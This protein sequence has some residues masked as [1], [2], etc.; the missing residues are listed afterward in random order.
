MRHSTLVASTVASSLLTEQSCRLRSGS[1]TTH[2]STG[3][4]LF[5]PNVPLLR[6]EHGLKAVITDLNAWLCSP[7][8]GDAPLELLLQAGGPYLILARCDF[9]LITL[10]S[11][12]PAEIIHVHSS[13]EPSIHRVGLLVC[14]TLCLAIQIVVT[15]QGGDPHCGRARCW[16]R[17]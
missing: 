10:L 13:A 4:I 17:T 6:Q 11:F 9:S 16:Q 12:P 1:L 3:L 7:D 2:P 5:P 8:N 15:P 14:F